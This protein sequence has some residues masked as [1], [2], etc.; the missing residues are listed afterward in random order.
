MFVRCERIIFSVYQ[1]DRDVVKD[2]SKK[3]WKWIYNS[4][5]KVCLGSRAYVIFQH[6]VVRL[7]FVVFYQSC[8]F[9]D[10]II[11]YTWK[12]RV[13]WYITARS[14]KNSFGGGNPSL[15]IFVPKGLK[16]PN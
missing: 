6:V 7:Y 2:L 3:D 5:K 12:C 15:D 4:R 9:L 8:S 10:E 1:A 14:I 13:K 11:F 16:T